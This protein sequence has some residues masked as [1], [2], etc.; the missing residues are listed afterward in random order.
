METSRVI[1]YGLGVEDGTADRESGKPREEINDLV[2][3]F[4]SDYIRG[5]YDGYDYS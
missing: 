4:N 2:I 3:L 1:A 5:Y